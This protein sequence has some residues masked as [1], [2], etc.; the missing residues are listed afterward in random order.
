M[1]FPIFFFWG[2]EGEGGAIKMEGDG[3]QTSPTP[4]WNI[5]YSLKWVMKNV[6]DHN[7]GSFT[8]ATVFPAW[9]ATVTQPQLAS[10]G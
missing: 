9:E 6:Y 5:I 8:F 10:C 4:I 3:N 1:Y 2:G 7:F